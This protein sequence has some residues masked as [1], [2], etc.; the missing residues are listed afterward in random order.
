MLRILFIIKIVVAERKDLDFSYIH[1]H[2]YAYIFVYM[3]MSMYACAYISFHI[4]FYFDFF[5][6]VACYKVFI[7]GCL[8]LSLCFPITNYFF[9]VRH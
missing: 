8:R 6:F 1:M 7:Q 5:P 3:C 2:I 9:N 4:F